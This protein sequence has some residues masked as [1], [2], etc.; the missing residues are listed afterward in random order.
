[1]WCKLYSSLSR[2]PRKSSISTSSA[3]SSGIT[4]P[5]KLS[6]GM[7]LVGGGIAF[8]TINERRAVKQDQLRAK[9]EQICQEL[10]ADGEQ[11]VSLLDNSLVIASADVYGDETVRDETFRVSHPNA[12]KLVRR[13]KMLQWVETK[14]TTEKVADGK[15]VETESY[16]YSKEWSSKSETFKGPN[17]PVTANPAFPTW[18]PGGEQRFSIKQFLFGIR[19]MILGPEL[20]D[21]LDDYKPLILKKGATNTA[22]V[23]CEYDGDDF[24]IIQDG[25][26]L[27]SKDRNPKIPEIGDIMVNYSYVEKGRHTLVA[28]YLHAANRLAPFTGSLKRS[29]ASEGEI[30]APEQAKQLTSGGSFLIPGWVIQFAEEV[31]LSL[32]PLQLCWISRGA[33]NKRDAFRKVAEADESTS[34]SLRYI[35]TG[36]IWFGVHSCMS[37]IPAGTPLFVLSLALAVTISLQTIREA[38]NRDPL[39]GDIELE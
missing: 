22:G 35:G 28:K 30:V 8:L 20:V 11:D 5:Q 4:V 24:V 23:T 26:A 6:F 37:M 7:V 15:T 2:V 16:H 1:M 32:A 38:G 31:V 12:I 17:P 29:L 39:R 27:Y 14:S 21:Q 33:Y 9:G 10:D 36:I 34:T 18:L 25:R 3:S 13:T 19:K